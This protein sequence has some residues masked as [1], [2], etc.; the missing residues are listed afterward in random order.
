MLLTPSQQRRRESFF[1]DDGRFDGFGGSFIVDLSQEQHF[2]VAGPFIPT[3]LKHSVIWCE[4]P[5]KRLGFGGEYLCWQGIN[6]I[7]GMS[8]ADAYLCPWT[9]LI[10]E[11]VLSDCQCRE[12]AGN[13]FHRAVIGPLMLYTLSALQP[14]ANVRLAPFRTITAPLLDGQDDEDDDIELHSQGRS[15]SDLGF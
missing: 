4:A 13:A 12:L 3:L 2:W 1:S 10:D 6:T 8:R 14:M 7:R 11:G 9:S 5:L 15:I